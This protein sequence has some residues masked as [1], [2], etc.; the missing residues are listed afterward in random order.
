[1]AGLTLALFDIDGTLIRGAGE[2]RGA[3]VKVA[4]VAV[5]KAMINL[6]VYCEIVEGRCRDVR[7][8]VGALTRIPHR[9]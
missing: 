4:P 7:V 9:I 8:A 6:G 2:G 5:D 1:M 3:F